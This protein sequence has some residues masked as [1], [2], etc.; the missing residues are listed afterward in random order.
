MG[1]TF[2]NKSKSITASE[3]LKNEF[4]WRNEQATVVVLDVAIVGMRTAYL[5]IERKG[6]T[7][8]NKQINEVYAMVCLLDYQ[9]KEYNN[10]GYKDM[11]EGC[12]PYY[13]DCPKRILDL[14]TPTD[15]E[16]ATKWRDTCLENLAKRESKPKLKTGCILKLDAPVKFSNGESLD[17]FFIEDAKRRVFRTDTSYHN[18]K[19]SKRILD[20]GYQVITKEESLKQVIKEGAEL[21]IL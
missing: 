18:Y 6:L 13:F 5:A 15:S 21:G 14:L 2:M 8:E 9:P 12:Q 17:T 19:L 4:T 7:M 3:F 20:R 10:F 16:G 1:W 11:E